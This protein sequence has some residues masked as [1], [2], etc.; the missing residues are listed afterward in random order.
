MPRAVVALLIFIAGLAALAAEA[1][2]RPA[3]TPSTG[4]RGVASLETVTLG[5][6]PQQV[7]IR[8]R[9]RSKPILLFLHGGPGMPLIPYAHAFQRPLEKDFVVVQ[10]DRR[11]T[12]N[13]Y[14][15]GMSPGSIRTSREFAD[16]LELIALLRE[17][18]GRDKVIIV[19]HSY[20]A[21]LGAWIAQQRPD[22]V[23][24][25]VGVGQAACDWPDVRAAQ[26][27][28]IRARAKAKGDRETARAAASGGA[29]DRIGAI[30]RYRGMLWRATRRGE[31]KAIAFRAP[32]YRLAEALR[33][34]EAS[35]FTRRSL[36]M[37]GPELPLERSI[38]RLEVPVHFFQGRHD[39][40]TPGVC[41]ARF[42]ER[43]AAPD[44]RLVWFEDSAHFPFLEEPGRFHAE[45]L[46]VA[47]SRR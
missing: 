40:V 43:L 34:D 16:A 41:V 38:P 7:L 31:L 13:S 12:G 11:G 33:M 25:F 15:P 44:K 3:Y 39:N 29:Y 22:L 27:S 6:T 36:R 19:G 9:D 30:W 21:W 42:Y 8:G 18:F 14:A 2:L 20:G 17:R 10:W 35:R 32:E 5:G 45:M 23:E 47:Q 26:D 46:K 28:W 4:A 24:A 1:W 37:D